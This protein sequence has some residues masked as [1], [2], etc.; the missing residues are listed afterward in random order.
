MQQPNLHCPGKEFL[1]DCWCPWGSF[2]NVLRNSSLFH[3]LYSTISW[4]C[5][6]NRR[7]VVNLS[8]NCENKIVGQSI[9]L[10]LIPLGG[11]VSKSLRGAVLQRRTHL[12]NWHSWR[13]VTDVQW[14]L[15]VIFQT[16]ILPWYSQE[17]YKMKTMY[18]GQ[19]ETKVTIELV[20]ACVIMTNTIQ[21]LYNSICDVEDGQ[22]DP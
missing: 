7:E 11:F 19:K 15:R 1:K 6:R 20:Q 10:S 21:A 8:Q 17:S 18:I 22:G 13:M 12:S 2:A 16:D 3:V 5:V 14:A 4:T 9:N